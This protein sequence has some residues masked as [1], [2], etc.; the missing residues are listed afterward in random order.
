MKL[1]NAT[2]LDRKPGQRR[3]GTCSFTFGD[4][5]SAVGESPPG[6]VSPSTQTAGPSPPLGYGR[7]DKVEGGA[8]PWQ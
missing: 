4:C 5:K 7:D 2:N 8:A 1:A 6:S 3:G